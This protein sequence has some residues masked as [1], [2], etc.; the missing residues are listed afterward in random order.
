MFRYIAHPDLFMSQR[1]EDEFNSVCQDAARDIALCAKAHHMP[2][3][4]K[5]SG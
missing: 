1:S 4:Y 2:I 5:M 3:E